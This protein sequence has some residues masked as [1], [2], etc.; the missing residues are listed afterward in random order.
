MKQG[1]TGFLKIKIDDVIKIDE[2]SSIVFTVTTPD[3]D[4]QFK[5]SYP[6]DVAY[7]DGYYYVPL[8]QED[9]VN[10]EGVYK[11]EAQ[12][13]MKN[14]EVVKTTIN[15]LFMNSSLHTT[16]L[17]SNPSFRQI[18]SLVDMKVEGIAIGRDGENGATFTPIMT[19]T[20][21]SWTNDK[22]LE[23]PEPV[24]LKGE[25]G[26]KGDPYTE[27]QEF[28]DYYE[29]VKE[30]V[31]KGQQVDKD[32]TDKSNAFNENSVNKTNAFNKNAET[33]TNEFNKN[34]TNKTTSFNENAVEK[35]NTF[36]QN[37]EQ[38]HENLKNDFNGKMNDLNE[39]YDTKM[40]DLEN[41]YDEKIAGLD[42]KSTELTK[43]F[44]DNATAKTNDFNA[45]SKKAQDDLSTAK[46]NAIKE[47]TD[48]KDK[49]I[50]EITAKGS[51]YDKRITAN[52]N[53]ISSIQEDIESN[54][55]T[56]PLIKTKST[57]DG[58]AYLTKSEN[59]EIK[60]MNIRGNTYQFTTNGYQLFNIDDVVDGYITATGLL[61]RQLGNNEKSSSDFL[62]IDSSKGTVTLRIKA[63]VS[64]NYNW[65]AIAYYDE[66]KTFI[67]RLVLT[68]VSGTGV[69]DENKTFAI[70]SNAK[71]FKGSFRKY[72]D[73]QMQIEYGSVVHDFEVYTGG[74]PSPSPDY[75][76]EVQCVDKIQVTFRSDTNKTQFINYTLDKPLCKL[77]DSVYDYLDLDRGKIVRNVGMITFDG[78]DEENWGK[79]YPSRVD[80]Y[81][82][83]I[84]L[85]ISLKSDIV[86]CDKLNYKNINKGDY[87]TGITT[88]S[89]DIIYIRIN[90]FST[91]NTIKSLKTYLSQNP[92]TVY[93]QLATPIEEDIPTELLN[94]LRALK[95]YHP[96]TFVQF[97]K[98]KVYPYADIK[99]MENTSLELKSIKNSYDRSLGYACVD[100]NVIGL[101]VDYDNGTFTRLAGAVGLEKGT[102]FDKFNMLGGRKRCNV[103]NDGTIKAYYGQSG[104]K[105]DGSNG[106]VMVYQPKFYYLVVPITYEP[107][108]NEVG[109]YHLKV[110]DYYVSD[111]PRPGFKLHPAFTNEDG[112]EVDYILIGAYEASIYDTS[113][114]S[115]L[116]Q[117]EQV[118]DFDKDLLCSI[119]NVKPCSG[120]TQNLTSANVEK[121][122]KNRGKGWH[123]TSIKDVSLEQLLMII[124]LGTMNTQEGIGKGVTSIT[125]NTSYNCAV[126]TG[127]T[128]SLGNT[129]GRA[130]K[131]IGYKGEDKTEYT[132]EW[133]T[134]IS[135]RGVENFW[136][137]IWK[138]IEGLRFWGNGHML[139]GQPYVC[140]DF[141]YTENKHS[142]NYEGVGFTLPNISSGYIKAMGYSHD[143]DW[144]FI[145]SKVG[146]DS[147]KPVGDY[148][149]VTQKLN[150]YRVPRL[151][152][153]WNDGSIAGGFCWSCNLDVGGRT[154]YIGGRLVYIPNL[155]KW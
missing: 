146:G 101:Q 6:D 108:D 115:Y 35:T 155:K 142:D 113:A 56:Q 28:K 8:F 69:K 114:N 49:A 152:G 13:N 140:K 75:P 94:Q 40:E 141:N 88:E 124:E 104:F 34:A 81:L 55:T 72:N 66:N 116:S 30:T 33:K 138:L 137:N 125:D 135:F 84:H 32:I 51:E 54:L 64:N 27:S 134:S 119:A 29:K 22:G 97:A 91:E 14:A 89:D 76:Q 143:Y 12:I 11:I 73:G 90:E 127:S 61:D 123:S 41:S 132:G 38:Q 59:R 53:N 107:I 1:A 60:G 20:V 110:A 17:D 4:L 105:E 21:L 26:D 43:A 99:Y 52:E 77:S 58:Y 83:Y 128:S 118:A 85:Y 71:Y 100:K 112:L 126:Q 79:T 31:E 122:A 144:L 148:T 106:Q 120:L 95:T 3:R 16:M 129:T 65:G 23:N 80:D 48:T 10:M 111:T 46:T 18:G 133:Q 151:G 15:K 36:N 68:G 47:V 103:A 37:A 70:P 131:S 74:M 109:G 2:V 153:F 136:G 57:K 19:G 139:G 93:Y 130:T 45:V 24:D 67:S 42:T 63:T 147:S 149:W 92:I 87:N 96:V 154:R 102:D 7:E 150:D 86:K 50:E 82:Y 121:L 39:S 5:K 44:N 25:K 9:T 62:P 98:E 145:P 78:S 117:D